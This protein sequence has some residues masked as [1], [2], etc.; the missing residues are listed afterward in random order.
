MKAFPALLVVYLIA[1]RRWTA[2][3]WALGTM[4]V[5]TALPVVWYGVDAGLGLPWE[6]LHLSGSDGWP[7]RSHNQSLFAMVGRWLGPEGITATGRLTLPEAPGVFAVW[8]VASA[9]LVAFCGVNLGRGADDRPQSLA[10]DMAVVL[11]LAVLL[12]P[13]AWDHYWVLF[14]PAF[15]LVL[16][17]RERLPESRLTQLYWTTAVMTSGVALLGREAWRLSRWV[18]LRCLAGVVIVV[19]V[20]LALRAARRGRRGTQYPLPD[21]APVKGKRPHRSGMR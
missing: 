5:L 12:S 11:A 7:V 8:A 20:S 6:W 3:G 15:L 14:F 1:R 19:A 18:S 4:A 21:P 10:E 13:I 2:A 16:S 17:L 9:A